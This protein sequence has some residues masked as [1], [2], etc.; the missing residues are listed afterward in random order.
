MSLKCFVGN[1]PHAATAQ[2]ND[3]YSYDANGNM[4]GRTVGGSSYT[5]SYD[6]G[7]R[8]IGVSGPSTSAIF[9]YDADG[10]P[11]VG[12]LEHRGRQHDVR[13]LLDPGYRAASEDAF[14]RAVLEHVGMFKL[15]G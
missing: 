1:Q 6:R 8:L 10:V 12:Y 7:N 14:A 11:R 3:S 5:L 2:G 4:T 15:H 9:L 13:D